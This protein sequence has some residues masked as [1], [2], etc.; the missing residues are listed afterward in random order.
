[1]KKLELSEEGN[2]IFGAAVKF[3]DT[4]YDD[5]TH[6]FVLCH[7]GRVYRLRKG[8]FLMESEDYHLEV[9]V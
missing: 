3:F 5:G 2:R 9:V 1:M 6:L 7:N 8:L 4:G